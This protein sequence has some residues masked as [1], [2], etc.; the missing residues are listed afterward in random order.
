MT[1]SP[2][3][4]TVDHIRPAALL[5][6]LALAVATTLQ[7]QERPEPKR[8]HFQNATVL[9]GW[10]QDSHGQRLRTFTTRPHK[11]ATNGKVPAIFFVGWLSC[12]SVEYPDP[13][14]KDGFGVLLRRLIE[15]SG[16]ATVRMD[17]SGVGESQG[18]CSRT[19]FSQELSG[20]QSV[21]EEMLKYDFIDPTKIFVVG[22]SNGGGISP[23]VPRQ[24]PVLGYIAVSSWGRTWYEHMLDL[25]RRR[26]LE[27]GKS[28][29]E[30]NASVKSFVEF[31]TLYLMKGM[32]PGQIVAQHPE[33]KS[34]WYDSPDGQYGRPAAY[35]QQLQALNLGGAWQNVNEPVLIIRGTGDNIMSRPD[36]ETIARIVNQIHSGHARYLQIDDLTHS[37]T[38]NNKFDDELIP[39]I[40][41]W[42]RDVADADERATGSR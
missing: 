37:L 15:Q 38:I 7:A 36:S 19:D 25:E 8:E 4:H 29:A 33:W 13:D 40:L 6:V 11:V 30:V 9:Y 28:P 17:K 3:I 18:D 16:Y 42:M 35:Y 34:L 21:F 32:T 10:A 2:M 20:Y 41:K 12:D 26:L 27:A 22:L 39:T 23:L 5:L 24:H 31:Y 14:T 1:R